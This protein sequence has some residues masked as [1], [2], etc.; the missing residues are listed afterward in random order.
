MYPAKDRAGKVTLSPPCGFS[1]R[2]KRPDDITYWLSGCGEADFI[3]HRDFQFKR[4][5][6]TGEYKD[7]TPKTIT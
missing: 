1:S 2:L 4:D 3:T 7:L 5:Q 6:S